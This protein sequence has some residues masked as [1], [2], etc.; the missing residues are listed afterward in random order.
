MAI[1][2]AVQAAL[3]HQVQFNTLMAK[4]T[5]IVAAAMLFIFEGA[6]SIGFQATVWVY[7]F[8]ILLLHL[9]QRGSAISTAAKWICNYMSPTI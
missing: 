6:F 3:I 9:R 2:M 1:F 8:E 7:S 4:S 5:G